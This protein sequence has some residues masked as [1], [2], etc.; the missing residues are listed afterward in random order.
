VV[1]YVG[2]F[3]PAVAVPLAASRGGEPATELTSSRSNT[4]DG[5]ATLGL[6]ASTHV[7]GN[8]GTT[9]S[10]RSYAADEVGRYYHQLSPKI[11]AI[12]EPRKGHPV[13]PCA[14]SYVALDADGRILVDG[15]G[16]PLAREM[17]PSFPFEIPY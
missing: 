7:W 14:F 1:S 16:A 11:G 2:R 6:W 3:A 8:G 17:L 15:D 5:D 12:K 9:R 4:T 13:G 10:K